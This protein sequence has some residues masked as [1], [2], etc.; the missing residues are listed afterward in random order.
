MLAEDLSFIP[1]A[2]SSIVNRNQ[3][4]IPDANL[5][6]IKVEQVN[7]EIVSGNIGV[8]SIGESFISGYNYYG[9]IDVV[10]LILVIFCAV[11]LTVFLVFLLTEPL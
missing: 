4:I 8:L 2:S 6:L 7:W 5:N 9:S 3:F 11:P 1:L 10:L